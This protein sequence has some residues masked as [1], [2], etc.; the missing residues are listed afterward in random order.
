MKIDIYI[1]MEDRE[2]EYTL[3]PYGERESPPEN[4]VAIHIKE[5]EEE[6]QFITY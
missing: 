4:S 3:W 1:E 2:K 5:S 6:K